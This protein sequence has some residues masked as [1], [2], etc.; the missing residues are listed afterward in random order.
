[1]LRKKI[2]VQPVADIQ[3]IVKLAQHDYWHTIQLKS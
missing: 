3:P 2:M 1:M